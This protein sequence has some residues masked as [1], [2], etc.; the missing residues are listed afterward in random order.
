MPRPSQSAI[1]VQ[2]VDGAERQ[3]GQVQG[4]RR[5]G[6]QAEADDVFRRVG[7][8]HR[9]HG[10]QRKARPGGGRRRPE[11]AAG[12]F[13]AERQ[14]QHRQ[15]GDQ[16]Q[17]L[18]LVLER[19]RD[20]QRGAADQQRPHGERA[21]PRDDQQDQQ[22][23][24]EQPGGDELGAHRAHLHR[25]AAGEGEKEQPEPGDAPIAHPH[26]QQR[27][28]GQHEAH[29]D[30]ERQHARGPRRRRPGVLERGRIGNRRQLRQRVDLQQADGM[31]QAQ[32]F[33]EQQDRQIAGMVE[34]FLRQSG[35]EQEAVIDDPEIHIGDAP[36]RVPE[37]G[38]QERGQHAA[39]D[40]QQLRSPRKR[41]QALDRRS[42]CVA[43]GSRPELGGR[44]AEGLH[45]EGLR[46]MV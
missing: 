24:E 46:E 7:R 18:D 20:Q 14:Q 17:D 9:H 2:Y 11:A 10:A 45:V 16:E 38:D 25:H 31:Q 44:G 4:C 33:G 37:A 34:I 43:G 39:A 26:A 36:I 8:E 1:S 15:R 3:R 22:R 32:P 13:R 23:A 41:N 6:R 21:A 40:E 29:A 28:E 27:A 42:R 30:R 5:Q 12:F 35:V 19:Q